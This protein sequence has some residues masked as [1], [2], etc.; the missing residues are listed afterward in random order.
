MKVHS[1]K[2]SGAQINCTV[3][4]MQFAVNLNDATTAHKLQ[5]MSKDFLII[6]AF[7]NKKL[8]AMFKNWE[9]VV[10]SR[11]FFRKSDLYLFDKI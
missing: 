4:M 7:P 9:C 2:F 1:S 6:P 5:G 11:I 3:V 10:L 8:Q